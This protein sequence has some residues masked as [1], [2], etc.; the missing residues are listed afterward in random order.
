[1]IKVYNCLRCSHE[2]PSKMSITPSR[3]PRCD[4]RGWQTPAPPPKLHIERKPKGPS[5]VYPVDK[6][7]IGQNM[8]IPWYRDPGT[9]HLNNSINRSVMAYSHRSGRRLFT[10]ATHKGLKVTRIS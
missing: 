3:C 7:E 4:S 6:L 10:E 9:E 8:V 1:M 5:R 2:W